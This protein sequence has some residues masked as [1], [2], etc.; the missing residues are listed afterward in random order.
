[1]GGTLLASASTCEVHGGGGGGGVGATTAQVAAE[2]P[3]P[4]RPPAV[5]AGAADAQPR[6]RIPQGEASPAA[7]FLSVS[8]RLLPFDLP[9]FNKTSIK[10]ATTSTSRIRFVA[11]SV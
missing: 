2:V 10:F 5:A 3:G 1:V 4:V 9:Q 7:A 11:C 8:L 6:D